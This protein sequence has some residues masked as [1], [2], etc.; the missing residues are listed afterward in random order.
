LAEYDNTNDG[1]AFPPF[2]DMKMILQGKMNVE[3]RDGKYTVVR[4]VTQSGMEIMEVYE[5]VGVMFKNESD[6]DTAPDYTGKLYDTAD[7]Q[8][9]WS[10]PQTDKRLAAWRRMKDG[11]PYMSFAI[12]DPQNKSEAQANNSL[13]VDEIPF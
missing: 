7:K 13:P 6:K 12:S 1:V 5:K 10:A 11:K 3:G 8:V 2:E 9:P 4:R